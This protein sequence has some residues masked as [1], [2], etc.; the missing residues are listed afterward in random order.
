TPTKPDNDTTGL[1]LVRAARYAATRPWFAIG[2]IDRSN[3]DEVVANGAN[4]VAVVRS[5]RDADDPEAAARALK[6]ALPPT[7]AVI[8]GD[9]DRLTKPHRLA[10]VRVDLP[11][12]AVLDTFVDTG[13]EGPEY[14]VH[15]LHADA[16]HVLEGALEFRL[17]TGMQRVEAGTSVVLPPGVPHTF[18]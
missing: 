2:G 14:H 6:A 18:R 10:V 17:E 7:T 5:I 13:F 11:H 4:G 1:E 12:I 8:T 15:L 3:V 16:F 9:G